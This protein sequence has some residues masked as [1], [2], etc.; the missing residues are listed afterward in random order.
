MKKAPSPI[1]AKEPSDS[2]NSTTSK[3]HRLTQSACSALLTNSLHNI[4]TM[5]LTIAV[6]LLTA[7][8][9]GGY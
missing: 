6:G 4:I 8:S 9:M 7:Y 3:L 2:L 1:T 5:L